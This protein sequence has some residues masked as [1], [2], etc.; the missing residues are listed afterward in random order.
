M[1]N[2]VKFLPNAIF[3]L[4]CNMYKS[5]M[6]ILINIRVITCMR[7][8]CTQVNVEFLE[9]MATRLPRALGHIP[10]IIEKESIHQFMDVLCTSFLKAVDTIGN[11]SK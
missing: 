6:K 4:E 5:K 10:C 1:N 9:M 2:H 11:Y 3:V 8:K 7:V